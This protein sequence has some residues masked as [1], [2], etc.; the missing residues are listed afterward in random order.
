MKNYISTIEDDEVKA[1]CIMSGSGFVMACD[2]M[3]DDDK[4]YEDVERLSKY[5]NCEKFVEPTF[6]GQKRIDK[7][8]N[9]TYAT[10]PHISIAMCD[11]LRTDE[12]K[13][14]ILDYCD[15]DFGLL[16]ELINLPRKKNKNR[17]K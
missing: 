12:G 6:K 8:K 5:Y 7:L 4:F 10:I 14:L 2:S 1:Y 17:E 3:R 9:R 16:D 13:K 15:F 11:F